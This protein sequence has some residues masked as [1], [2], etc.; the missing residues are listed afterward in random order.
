MSLS[1]LADPSLPIVADAST[2]IN[3]NGSGCAK[4]ILRALPNRLVVTD[5]VLAELRLDKRSGRDDAKLIAALVDEDLVTIVEL[6]HLKE[7]HFEGLVAGPA[8]E[9]LDDGEAATIACAIEKKAVALIDERK[10][11]A[12][13]ARK[14]PSLVVGRTVDVFAHDAVA[15][16][17]GRAA[18]ADAVFSTLQK[19][20]MRVSPHHETWIVD[21]IGNA[22]ARA[23][24][25]LPARL[26][27]GR[28]DTISSI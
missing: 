14:H 15:M 6:A 23:C 26:R 24:P 19:A 25:S 28:A 16:A 3:L 20:R 11:I 12:L 1:C 2:V 7:D 4:A 21:L 17:L 8:S 13:C 5:T 27:V 9:T 22:R 10:A 18:L